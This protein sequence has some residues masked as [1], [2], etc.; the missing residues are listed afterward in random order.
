M[1]KIGGL[2]IIIQFCID[3]EKSKAWYADFLGIEPIA[4][5]AGLFAL[6]DGTRFH[7]APATP[8]TGRGGSAVYFYVPS[9]D[10][11][12]AELRGRGYA[13]NE[14]P[15]DIPVGRLV[16]LYDPDGNIVGLEDRSKGGLPS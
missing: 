14:E 1:L 9:V 4:Y 12:Y 5:G 2:E 6:D 7:L 8:G 15:Y 13:F 10:E 16:T 11:A 3:T